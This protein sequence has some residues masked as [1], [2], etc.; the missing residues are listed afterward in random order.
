VIVT[1]HV[2]QRER[3]LRSGRLLK[4]IEPTPAA[5][6]VREEALEVASRHG[7]ASAGGN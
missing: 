6:S 3:A 2:T 4:S 5:P 1:A 7:A